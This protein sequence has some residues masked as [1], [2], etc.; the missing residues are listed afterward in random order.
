M[1]IANELFFESGFT[2][3]AGC[4]FTVLIYLISWC[5]RPHRFPPGPRGVPLLGYIPFIKTRLE[6]TAFN[7]SQKYGPVISIR[8]GTEDHIVLNDYDS[9]HQV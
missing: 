7:L 3:I 4:A 2:L 9:I 6:Q 1:S 8:L 5:R